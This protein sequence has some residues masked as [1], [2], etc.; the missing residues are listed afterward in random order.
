[1]AFRNRSLIS[2]AIIVFVIMGA[3][4]AYS[5]TVGITEATQESD[6]MN[7]SYQK[8]NLNPVQDS[9]IEKLNP[10]QNYGKENDLWVVD[11]PDNWTTRSLLKFDLSGI[12]PE[13]EIHNATLE[14]YLYKYDD[15]DNYEVSI[16]ALNDS[17]TETGVTWNNVPTYSSDPIDISTVG[18]PKPPHYVS[19]DVTN[20]MDNML[21]TNYGFLVKMANEN[22]G[23]PWKMKMFRSRENSTYSPKLDIEYSQW[24]SYI[25][26]TED[27][28]IEIS[29]PDPTEDN[30]VTSG[31]TITFP[32][33]GYRVKDWGKVSQRD[34]IFYVNTEIEKYTGPSPQAIKTVDNSYSLDC[35][36]EGSYEFRFMAWDE[37]VET[38]EFTVKESEVS[39]E[40]SINV[41]GDGNT[42]PHIGTH[43]FEKEEE[44]TVKA[45]PENGWEF[46]EWTGDIS[47]K[48][49]EITVVMDN[50]KEITANFD[51]V[52]QEEKPEEGPEE[53]LP[54]RWVGVGAII[55]T[56]IIIILILSKMKKF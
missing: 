34:N 11:Y 13:A 55:I 21:K 18:F 2:L 19:W 33:M 54:W 29:P 9:Y 46:L 41:E 27:V 4:A 43:T 39:P 49:K 25:S 36:E 37:I 42:D 28:E 1:M 16:H 56:I 23:N 53:S 51:E 12:P 48:E 22:N 40:L 14:L 45:F 17:W 10:S 32:D 20:A 15:A 5:V 24:V 38:K 6:N 47:S 44:V 3:M 35:L 26:G 52:V 31:V 30:K 7:G 50:D 8:I